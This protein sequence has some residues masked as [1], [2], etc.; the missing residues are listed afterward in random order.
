[1]ID[2]YPK[3]MRRSISILSAA[4]NAWLEF[5]QYNIASAVGK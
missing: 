5:M 1:M 4:L 3:D 2:L